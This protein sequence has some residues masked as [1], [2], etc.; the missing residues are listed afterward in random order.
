MAR[1]N[2]AQK[3][4][5]RVTHEGAPAVHLTPEKLLRRLVGSCFLWEDNFYVD[6][7]TIAKQIVDTARKCRP[8]VVASLAIEAREVFNLRHV[9]LLLVDVLSEVPSRTKSA[10]EL[11]EVFG[12]D[13]TV[14]I[15]DVIERVIQRPDELAELLAIHWRDATP[16]HK[17]PVSHQMRKGIAKAFGKFKEYQLSKYKNG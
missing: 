9:P 4:P 3:R 2:V 10:V 15:A 8:A 1:L 12:Y 7:R 6:G 14:T 5:S 11:A 17:N 16:E 13:N